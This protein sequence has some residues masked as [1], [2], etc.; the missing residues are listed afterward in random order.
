MFV[1]QIITEFQTI[2]MEMMLKKCI[3]YEPVIIVKS[4]TFDIVSDIQLRLNP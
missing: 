2:E 1:P 4:I 3:F